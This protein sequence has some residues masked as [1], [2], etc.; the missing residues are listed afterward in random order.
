MADIR[1]QGNSN[2]DPSPSPKKIT[3]PSAKEKTTENPTPEMLEVLHELDKM[4]E[5]TTGM[6]SKQHIDTIKSELFS[7]ETISSKKEYS[8]EEIKLKLEMLV[9]KSSLD[10]SSR[11]SRFYVKGTF[12]PVT[13][14]KSLTE[15][16]K[17]MNDEISK[18]VT[19]T[20]STN[21]TT[22]TTTA[23]AEE[24]A[25]D[26]L[27][28]GEYSSSYAFMIQ[29]LTSVSE[30]VAALEVTIADLAADSEEYNN[31]INQSYID[32]AQDALDQAIRLTKLIEKYNKQEKS[33]S[34]IQEAAYIAITVSMCALA[35]VTCQP[36]LAM[37][38]V[39]MLVLQETGAM[40]K[41]TTAISDGLQ[42]TTGLSPATA[43]ILADVI[44][45]FLMALLTMGIGAASGMA[46]VA[47]EQTML[48]TEIAAK[49]A[50]GEVALT[51]GRSAA[52]QDAAIAA[53][54]AAL[55][56]GETAEEAVAAG[57]RAAIN[58]TRLEAEQAAT[59]AG[60][61]VEEIAEA[62][63][64]A[65]IKQ[66]RM[67]A[68]QTTLTAKGT[69]KEAVAAGKEAAINQSRIEAEQTIRFEIIRDLS[70]ESQQALVQ[71]EQEALLAGATEEEASEIGFQAALRQTQVEAEAQGAVEGA[72]VRTGIAN[73]KR[74]VIEAGEK[75]AAD[76]AA[77]QIETWVAFS[78][79]MS[80]MTKLRAMNAIIQSTILLQ[81]GFWS[82]LGVLCAKATPQDDELAWTMG[83]QTAGTLL[84]LSTSF[85][86]GSALVRTEA[87]A[88]GAATEES[89]LSTYCK[90]LS[91]ILV[92][93]NK[94]LTTTNI[95]KMATVTNL[96]G[97]IMEGA[98]SIALGV[99]GMEEAFAQK[100]LTKAYAK[101]SF[102]QN[103]EDSVISKTS[104]YNSIITDLGEVITN[105]LQG[106]LTA[107]TKLARM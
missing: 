73:C 78:S 91:D 29:S 14:L 63:R 41:L 36:E 82:D 75:A 32:A 62:G 44:V 37:M 7:K 105:T 95:V 70:P 92:G 50:A 38:A 107:T 30:A 28:D 15:E 43:D 71:A 17:A 104:F 27:F 53:E 98:A 1:V 80:Q 87:T 31:T 47:E 34:K 21:T 76:Q 46:V 12:S 93:M 33:S 42:K 102:Y 66:A 65:A 11:A 2:V 88:A 64:K 54:Q 39:G 8:P 79:R 81:T 55:T 13:G 18:S 97:G 51:A 4:L 49:K 85:S 77:S 24:E 68:E 74:E 19:T 40:E 94:N 59:A 22:T 5:A 16:L 90:K 57:S 99:Y 61:S 26:T 84:A 25:S 58:Q 89:F 9:E 45:A 96:L 106:G 35:V 67:E 86:A 83:M 103:M 23:T 72:A 56:A 69:T 48:A 20:S 3:T 60:K 6:R 52:A 100:E 101:A 10:P